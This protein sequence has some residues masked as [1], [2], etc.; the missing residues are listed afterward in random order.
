MIFSLHY[1]SY[2]QQERQRER[3]KKDESNQLLG[4]THIDTCNTHTDR[5][6]ELYF[7]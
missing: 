5:E 4:H 6:R 3:G 7:A 1:T 2:R